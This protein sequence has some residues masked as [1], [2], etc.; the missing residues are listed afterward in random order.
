[1]AVPACGSARGKSHIH[2]ATTVGCCSCAVMTGRCC[3]YAGISSA[4]WWGAH[5]AR[6]AYKQTPR[7]RLRLG[8]AHDVEDLRARR[9]GGEVFGSVTRHGQSLEAGEKCALAEALRS[10][11]CRA[12]MHNRHAALPCPAPPGGAHL[13][14]DDDDVHVDLFWRRVRT[15]V[16]AKKRRVRAQGWTSG[17]AG[18]QA[19]CASRRQCESPPHAAATVLPLLT[20]AQKCRPCNSPGMPAQPTHLH[21]G[22]DVFVRADGHRALAHHQLQQAGQRPVGCVC[23]SAQAAQGACVGDST[24][25]EHPKDS[26]STCDCPRL[27]AA[28][29]DVVD[30]VG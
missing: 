17:Q 16:G 20:A 4:E 3:R 26:M 23:I 27:R 18:E 2:F 28:C 21:R 12:C 14:E 19:V 30:E 25:G 8:D 1:M 11:L 24:K 9:W 15:E 13:E 22:E 29:L 5:C 10:A 7:Q 6:C